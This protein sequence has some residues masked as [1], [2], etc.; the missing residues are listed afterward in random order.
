[1]EN[2]IR[3]PIQ[4][5]VDS[6]RNLCLGYTGEQNAQLIQ[7]DVSK[8][9]EKWPGASI[10]LMLALPGEKASY[11]AKTE[12]KDGKLLFL[13]GYGDTQK[14]GHGAAYVVATKD[15]THLA[16]SDTVLTE[17]MHKGRGGDEMPEAPEAQ[18][19]WVADVLNAANRA[20]EAATSTA[21]NVGQAESAANRAEEAA[22][23]AENAKPNP[24]NEQNLIDRLTTPFSVTG[25]VA[26]C[27][28]VSDYPL[29]V[30][31]H[32]EPKQDGSGDPSPSNV[33]P[34]S[35]WNGINAWRS[36]ANLYNPDTI[37]KGYALSTTGGTYVSASS[38]TTDYIPVK[39]GQRIVIGWS[40]IRWGCFYAT[41]E[42]NSFI[43]IFSSSEINVPLNAKFVRVTAPIGDEKTLFV[44]YASS[45][46]NVAA[47]QDVQHLTAQFGQTIYGGD[48]DWEKGIVTKRFHHFAFDGV[49]SG[50][51]ID[52]TD[53]GVTT[54][55]YIA[56]N[57]PEKPILH[58]GRAYANKLKSVGTS[59]VISFGL[60]DDLTGVTR[61]DDVA[62]VVAKY[63]A[64]LKQWYEAGEPLEI[65][66]E[67][68]M[69]EEIQLTPQQILSLDGEN[70]LWSDCGKT[71]VSGP[72]S[73]KETEKRIAALEAAIAN[74]A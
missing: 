17:I 43:N 67:L 38:L 19:G 70:N 46:E 9:Q 25:D 54:Y 50:R 63:N 34:I 12:L 61:S 65:V 72:N 69:P 2:G 62:T 58:N 39:G 3:P 32:I 45:S 73:P 59:T 55:A 57:N 71:T 29:G 21:Q 52:S 18:A 11:P 31:S 66:Y 47:Y 1:M 74:M 35:G 68:K 7:I 40:E 27:L 48:Y 49:T 42:P 23:K 13:P 60:P 14:P 30:I 15:G 24:E 33:R 51:K 64:V 4:M 36:G 41:E 20:E 28:P 56:P 44:G 5:A 10:D 26:K 53:P 37:A 6:M 16:A 22:E 8:W